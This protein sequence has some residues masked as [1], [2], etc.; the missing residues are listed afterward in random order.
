VSGRADAVRADSVTSAVSGGNNSPIGP[1][2]VHRWTRQSYLELGALPSAV[3]CARLHAQQVV[4]ESGLH[5][6][7]ETVGLLV[8]ELVTNAVKVT[9]AQNLPAPVRLQLSGDTTQVLIEVWDADPT[10]PAPK[11]RD[12]SDVPDFDAEGGRGLLIVEALSERWSWY[13]ARQWG[14]KVVWAVIS[15]P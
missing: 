15:L 8:S 12:E 10:P 5:E 1:T 4:R 2:P 6:L 11:E 14:G 13:P 9:A 7:A 3:P